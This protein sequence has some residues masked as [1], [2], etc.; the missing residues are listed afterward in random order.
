MRI[1]AEAPDKAKA[2]QYVAN[3]R[4]VVDGALISN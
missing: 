1:I 4:A 3:V 2:M